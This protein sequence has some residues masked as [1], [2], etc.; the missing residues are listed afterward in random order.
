MITRGGRVSDIDG[1]S[2]LQT[3]YLYSNLSEQE[4]LAGFVTTPFSAGQFAALLREDGVYVAV[5]DDEVVGYA[6]AGSWEF[7]SQWPIFPFMV[8]RLP[9]LNFS[10][11]A[12]TSAN[13]F[14]Y[15]PVCIDERYRGSGLFPRLFEQMRVGFSH[16]YPVGVTFINRVN[17]R[18]YI[19][20]TRKLG[21][22]TIDQF[23][24]NG[25][26]YYGL[27]FDTGVSVLSVAF[28]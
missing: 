2:A 4:R 7:F 21:M 17:Q 25:R 10:G 15:G 20:H 22:Q 16:R 3:R 5:A 6:L 14:Q 24:F 9:A 11:R 18:S 26:P 19:A 12:V 8:A 1:I 27:A 23:E 28:S 13:S